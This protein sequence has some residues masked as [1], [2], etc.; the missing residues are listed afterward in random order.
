MEPVWIDDRDALAIHDRML[1]LHGGASGVRDSGLLESALARPQQRQ[2]YASIA[3][4]I[5]LAAAYA[6]GIV[7][8]HP[9]IDGNKRTGFVVSVLFLELNGSR[10]EAAENEAAEAILR[11]AAGTLDE[12][13]YGAFLQLNTRP[14]A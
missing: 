8:N 11:M 3:T 6:F 1:V 10:F 9:F 13:G 2:A 4:L 5:D 7:G 12:A 14:A